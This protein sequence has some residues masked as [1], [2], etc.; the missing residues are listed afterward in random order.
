M[1]VL[2]ALAVLFTAN[3]APYLREIRSAQWPSTDAAI[4]FSGLQAGYFRQL[5]GFLPD[6]RYSYSVGN[7]NYTGSRV[8][9]HQHLTA[10]DTAE[11]M[12][13]P[14]PVGKIVRVYYDPADPS[15]AVLE[16]GIKAE[17]RFLFYGNLSLILACAAMF[18]KALYKYARSRGS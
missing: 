16:P 3:L 1:F 15:C 2:L 5:K 8:D 13:A 7:V 11:A 6:V 9:F 4:K 10:R 12:I 18:L 14:Y 17:Q